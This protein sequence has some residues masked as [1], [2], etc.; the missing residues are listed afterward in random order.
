M[1]NKST[2]QKTIAYEL[3]LSINTVSRALRDC[4]DISASTKEAV[5]KKAY[6]I[7]YMPASLSKFI[8][9]DARPL[10]AI[11]INGFDN[12]YFI[13]TAR[14]LLNAIA[15]GNYDYT[16]IDNAGDSLRPDVIKQ[17]I[18][19]R[20]DGIVTLVDLSA[21]AVEDAYYASIPMVFVGSRCPFSQVDE[22][23][24]DVERGCSIAANYLIN[25]HHIK[26]LVYV[27]HVKAIRSEERKISFENAVKKIDPKVSVK[28]VL[29]TDVAAQLPKLIYEGYLGV[30][31]FNDETA[32]NAIAEMNK[33]IPNIRRIYPKLHII[34]FDGIASQMVG[35]TDLASIVYDYG[36]A[37]QKA[38]ELLAKRMKDIKRPK[39]SVVIDV[40]LHQRQIN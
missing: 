17:C 1:S 31:C 29:V 38:I 23:Y 28:T 5:R 13:I 19:Q 32:Y 21:K 10:I 11:L 15:R 3:G 27:S 35:M 40:S 2:G 37:C 39:E 26:K 18:S 12:Y 36:E 6:E 9:R 7:G 25:Y 22:V 34:G 30:F 20:V 8:K 24:P 33:M 4:D 14:H 16:I